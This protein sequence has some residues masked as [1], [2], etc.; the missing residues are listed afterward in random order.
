MKMTSLKSRITTLVIV[1]LVVTCLMLVSSLFIYYRFRVSAFINTVTEKLSAT[2]HTQADSLV[3]GY[4]LPEQKSG[5]TLLLEKFR[6]D[7]DLTASDI[8]DKPIAGFEKC[9]FEAVTMT[10]LNS[11]NNQV[12]VITP[13]KE[14]DY[15]YGYFFKAKEIKLDNM[16]S[17]F[18]RLS[19][20]IVICL[21]I[22][23]VILITNLAKITSVSI[24][25]YLDNLVLWL[26]HTL[27]GNK[28]SEPPS[29]H[30]QEFQDLTGKIDEIVKQHK[31][32]QERAAIADFASQVAHDIRSPL[33]ALTVVADVLPQLSEDKRILIRSS[34]GRIRDIANNLLDKS[35]EVLRSQKIVEQQ[36]EEELVAVELLSSLLDRLVTEKR[37]QFRTKIAI[38]IEAKLDAASYGLF[39]KIQPNAFKRVLSNLINNAVEA[40]SDKGKVEV[41]IKADGMAIILE[42]KDNG[43]G[44]A[45]D[46]LKK[47]MQKGETFGKQGGTGLGLYHARTSIESWNGTVDLQSELNK[48]TVVRIQL[49]KTEPPQWFVPEV[50]LAPHST[51]AIFDDDISIHQI[52]QTRLDALKIT[53]RNI[54]VLHFSNP[55][56]ITAWT[57]KNR[58]CNNALYLV[59]YEL[60]GNQKTGLQI[61]EGLNIEQQSI[62]VTSRYE[63]K[64]VV[65]EC[66]RLGVKLIPKAMAGF[67]PIAFSGES[68]TL[69]GIVID[70]DKLIH[71]SWE[72]MAE[73]HGKKLR[74]FFNAN[75][76]LTESAQFNLTTP[77]YIDSNLGDGIKGEEQAKIIHVKGF[78]NIYLMTGYSGQYFES[79]PWIKQII[80]KDPPWLK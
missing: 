55:D 31:K 53:E 41:T 68:E 56:E 71:M 35:R 50:K 14:G 23:F 66:T 9:Q 25:K 38:E 75:D 34:V 43:K 1:T 48:G 52:W 21:F 30:F 7:E 36:L 69:D 5:I 18:F 39:A 67:V 16:N 20:L 27:E 62:L 77:I 28:I 17:D 12:G 37:M 3:I 4:L 80:G 40:L 74:L 49:P 47:L 15:T 22:A 42:V 10:C 64:D 46:V 26:G 29:T 59:D 32:L 79:M 54:S 51:I 63:E 73:K 78:N 45:P 61:I 6:R 19:V 72:L 70:D 24:P 60:I 11:K 33:A 58:S 44:I 8:V 2:I 13:I 57:T 76:F 65:D